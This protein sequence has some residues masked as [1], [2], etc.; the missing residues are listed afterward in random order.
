MINSNNITQVP[1]FKFIFFFIALFAVGCSI[2]E[3]KDSSVFQTRGIILDVDDLSTVDWPKLA[4]ESGITTI[5]THIT[6]EQVVKFIQSESGQHFL[7]ECKKYGIEVEHELHAM[8]DLLPRKLFDEDS[9][10]FRMDEHGKRVRE[11]NLCTHSQ[12]AL[13]IVRDNAVKYSKLLPSTTGRYFYW[14]DDGV[15][16]CKCPEC[17]EYS[18]SDLSLI[19]ANNIIKSLRE[20]IDPNATLAHLAYHTTIEA[21]TKVKPEE[22]IFLE[23]APFHRSFTASLKDTSAFREEFEITHGDY[24]RLLD[25]NLAVFP[26]ETAQVLEYWLDVS[27]FSNWKKPAVKLPWNKEVFL[28]DMDVYGKRGI[29]HITTFGVYIDSAYI[30]NY[31]DLTFL[32][33][34]GEG[35]KNY[36]IKE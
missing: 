13:Q 16:M 7:D 31:S 15:P 4:K 10:M 2:S 21:P 8:G 26:V 29:K 19:V 35:L 33:D 20:E 24:L 3:E 1:F 30:N 22:G 36:R 12:K 23:F 9:T 18:D 14:I 32:E 6:P 34:Y 25:D 5:A 28:D 27:L 11:Y 17:N